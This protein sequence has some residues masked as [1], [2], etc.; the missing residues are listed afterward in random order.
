VHWG[1]LVNLLPTLTC[2][3]KA[4]A[5]DWAVEG[6]VELKSLGE[7]EERGERK[8]GEGEGEGEGRKEGRKM[9]QEEDD[10]DSTWL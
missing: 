3:I 5:G 2:K 1:L 7:K 8:E 10:P 6:K 4:R 9:E